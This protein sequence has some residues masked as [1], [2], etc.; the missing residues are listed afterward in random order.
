MRFWRF[1]KPMIAA[2]RGPCLAGACELALACDLT[3]AADDAFFG[4]PELKFGAGIVVMLLPWIV[5]PKLAK[6]IILTGE[7]RIPAARAREI[8]MVNRV[9]AADELEAAALAT[10]RRIAAMDPDL[11]RETKRAINRTFEAQGMAEA[12]EAAL[13]ID[14]QIEG[15]G[16]PDKIAF[17][18]VARRAGLKAALAWRDA[19][20]AGGGP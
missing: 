5:G 2:V 4:E 3:I 15:Q 6:E 7:D 8:G 14:L 10:A 16:S 13:D 19:R 12:L 1:P 20:F 17:M 9:V 18:E 11:V